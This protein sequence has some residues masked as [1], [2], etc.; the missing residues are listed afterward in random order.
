[1][2][3]VKLLLFQLS[4]YDHMTKWICSDKRRN[5][6]HAR[7]DCWYST[8]GSGERR[9][10]S[11]YR[12]SIPRPCLFQ[13]QFI[14]YHAPGNSRIITHYTVERCQGGTVLGRKC[15]RLFILNMCSVQHH[16]EPARAWAPGE[17]CGWE[18]LPFGNHS[19]NTYH[20]N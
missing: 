11:T 14:K 18:Q 17:R 2:E 19:L 4:Q 12:Q 15:F 10:K 20:T 5:D 1:M 7:L 16:T 3:I 8:L 9:E 6:F 13:L